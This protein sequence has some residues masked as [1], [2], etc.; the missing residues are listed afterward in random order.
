MSKIIIITEKNNISDIE[1]VLRI[2]TPNV[3]VV[4]IGS[5]FVGGIKKG[6]AGDE[7]ILFFNYDDLKSREACKFLESDK[8]SFGFSEKADF[9][10]SDQIDTEEG[11]SFKLN[12]RGNSVPIWIKSPFDKEKIYNIL[13]AICVAEFSGLNIVEIS[14]QLKNLPGQIPTVQ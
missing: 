8:I 3:K 1:K 4:F 9:F 5:E 12:Y 6:D 11:I 14:E 7:A 2:L 10:A 13:A